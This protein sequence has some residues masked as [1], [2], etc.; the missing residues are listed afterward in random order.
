MMTQIITKQS[1]KGYIQYRSKAKCGMVTDGRETNSRGYQKILLYTWKYSPIFYL[2][3]IKLS[4]AKI[5]LYTVL[6][7]A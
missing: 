4:G 6:F 1:Q 5:T 7:F 2:Y 3:F